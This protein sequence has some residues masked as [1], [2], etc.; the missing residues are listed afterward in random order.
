MGKSKWPDFLFTL[1][2][3]LFC[4]VFLGGLLCVLIGY[5]GILNSFA[6][7]HIGLIFPHLKGFLSKIYLACAGFML[8]KCCL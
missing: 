7:N 6:H 2:V 8:L 4:G 5:R 1:A 3:R